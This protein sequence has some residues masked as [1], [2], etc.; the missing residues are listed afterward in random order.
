M[1]TRNNS[2]PSRGKSPRNS[3]KA[4]SVS[5][6]IASP[7]KS[8]RKSPVKRASASPRKSPTRQAKKTRFASAADSIQ[9]ADDTVNS[10]EGLPTAGEQAP[11]SHVEPE[12]PPSSV[13]PSLVVPDALAQMLASHSDPAIQQ[14]GALLGTMSAEL[15][16]SK[17]TNATLEARISQQA[18]EARRRQEVRDFEERGRSTFH[19]PSEALARM[20]TEFVY[21]HISDD[22]TR[23]YYDGFVISEADQ[24]Q[25]TRA[26][27]LVTKL[28]KSVRTGVLTRQLRDSFLSTRPRE[29]SSHDKLHYSSE[30]LATDKRL[31][32]SHEDF[33]PV[34][35]VLYHMLDTVS[36]PFEVDNWDAEAEFNVLHRVSH[37]LCTMLLEYYGKH[38]VQPRRDIFEKA[39]GLRVTPGDQSS[40]FLTAVE[41]DS[42]MEEA[43]R[44]DLI[45]HHASTLNPSQRGRGNQGRGNRGRGQQRGRGN[46]GRGNLRH[47]HPSGANTQQKSTPAAAS[48]AAA[49]QAVDAPRQPASTSPQSKGPKGGGRG[50][51]G[52]G[53]GK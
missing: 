15:E 8:P 30:Q 19:F 42:A 45:L 12:A 18:E 44:Q 7:R 1:R 24:D 16:K 10:D 37:D 50:R 32:Q 9:Q 53:K 51:G 4:V 14:M 27:S 3:P 48:P 25:V 47:L 5:A 35:Q 40:G 46:R 39:T 29:L 52:G 34:L 28:P 22:A 26:F 21:P 13:A 43:R 38:I 41:A 33:S 31:V 6:T 11:P 17:S 2:T 20:F 23:R 49:A 36:R